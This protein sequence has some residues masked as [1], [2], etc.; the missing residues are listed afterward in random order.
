[1]VSSALVCSQRTRHNSEV[2]L[3]FLGDPSLP[4]TVAVTGGL[5]RG[6]HP[7]EHSNAT[8][9]RAAI[10]A[11][12]A[13]GE[14][15]G[16]PASSLHPDLKGFRVLEQCGLYGAITEALSLARADGT[17][18]P[19]LLLAQ[20]APPLKKVLSDHLVV[21]GRAGDVVGAASAAADASGTKRPLRDMVIVLGDHIGLSSEEEARVAELGSSVGGG[22]PVLRAS[23]GQ[24]A[25]LASQCIVIVHHYLD[26]LHDCPAQLWQPSSAAKHASRQRH[27][28][29]KRSTK[30]WH[31]ILAWDSSGSS[32]D[33]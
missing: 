9:L 11:L 22:G 29:I 5:V 32:S 15:H 28:R 21:G 24:G 8:R 19:L 3:P 30:S 26:A 4:S 25:L 6:L 10:D 2:W 17:H 27:R 31:Q 7:S 33:C 1:M 18:A 23:L 16:K 20:D 12:G 14:D 13:G